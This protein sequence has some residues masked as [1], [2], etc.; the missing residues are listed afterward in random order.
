METHMTELSF[1]A[2]FTYGAPLYPFALAAALLFGVLVLEVILATIAG[3]SLLGAEIGIGDVDAEVDFD[4]N[5]PDVDA[6]IQLGLGESA[7]VDASGGLIRWF[8]IGSVPIMVWIV[9]FAASFSIV[10]FVGQFVLNGLTGF[11]IPALM[12]TLLAFIPALV[13]TKWISHIFAALVPKTTTDVVS[14]RSLAGSLGKIAYGVATRDLPARAEVRDRHGN[15]HNL[16][17]KP[18]SGEPDL[19]QGTDVLILRGPGPVYEALSLASAQS[20]LQSL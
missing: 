15:L 4:V 19:P 18:F 11:M 14:K 1:D 6:D 20:R 13:G 16:Q 2:V 12:A 7:D 5:V 17:V 8:E 3:L 10:G 9:A